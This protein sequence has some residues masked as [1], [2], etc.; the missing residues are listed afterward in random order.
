MSERI[1]DKVV[2][3]GSGARNEFR[4]V[5]LLGSDGVFSSELLGQT[6]EKDAVLFAL[7]YSDTHGIPHN[8]GPKSLRMARECAVESL[9]KENEELRVKLAETELCLDFQ[10]QKSDALVKENEE[11]KAAIVRL[12]TP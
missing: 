3:I 8:L 4:R 11:F 1:P 10:R 5:M 12:M 7:E 2:V 6:T 9:R